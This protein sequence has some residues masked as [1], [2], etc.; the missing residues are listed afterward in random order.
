MCSSDLMVML[1]N[2]DI[3][4][5]DDAVYIESRGDYYHQDDDRICF[6]EDTEQHE[7]VDDCWQCTET[8]KWYTDAIDYVEVDGDKYHP[9]DAPA[10]ET[11]GESE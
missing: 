3:V 10:N 8:A 5:I 7:L 2:G 4:P 1:H 9:D 11:E 6:A